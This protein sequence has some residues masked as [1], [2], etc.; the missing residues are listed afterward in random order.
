MISET[1]I[2]SAYYFVIAIEFMLA[3]FILLS[4][5]KALANRA[6]AA[7]LIIFGINTVVSS[8][9]VTAFT[10]KDAGVWLQM[11]VA[12]TYIIGPAIF[13]TA[14]AVLRPT[15]FARRWFRWLIVGFLLLP[16]VS[17]L[18]D[19]SGFSQTVFNSHL[20]YQH[21]DVPYITV[22]TPLNLIP[23]GL[24]RGLFTVIAAG[25][26]V[27]SLL[28]PSLLVAIQ[29]RK[30]KPQNSRTA[31]VLFF[32]ILTGSALE[33]FS[34]LEKVPLPRDLITLTSSVT[35]LL[36]FTYAG[37]KQQE[38]PLNFR[39]IRHV[40]G[41]WP[42]AVKLIFI[43][44]TVIIPTIL[45]ANLVTLTIIR[46]SIA[47][48]VGDNLKSLAT[49]QARN[50]GD[51]ILIEVNNL[52]NQVVQK[53]LINFSIQK[54]NT[55]SYT[56]R[57]EQTIEAEIM[58]RDRLMQFGDEGDLP[59]LTG[60]PSTTKFEID[61]FVKLF[62]NHETVLL[63]DQR[64][65]LFTA[66]YRPYQYDFSKT[67]WWQAAYNGGQGAIYIS[68]PIYNAETQT[69]FVE[70]A[71]PV[72]ELREITGI[73]LSQYSLA[74][75]SRLLGQTNLGETG[76]AELFDANGNWQRIHTNEAPVEDVVDWNLLTEQEEDRGHQMFFAGVDSVIGVSPVDSI[77]ATAD[78]SLKNLGWHVL[79]HQSMNEASGAATLAARASFLVGAGTLIASIALAYIMSGFI[80]RP[81]AGLTDAAAKVTAGELD[82]HADVQ[83]K[84]EFG[85]L[86]TTFNSMTS[87]IKSLVS[88]LE[89]QVAARTVD[90]ERRAIQLQTA[91]EVGR[92]A[93]S[94]RDLDELLTQVTYLISERFDFYHTGIFIIDDTHE[95]AVLRATNS[96]GGQ[97]ML[98]RN[99]RLE[100]GK[101]IV[102]YVISEHEPRIALNVGQDA[103]HFQ[104]PDLPATRSEMALP[105]IT[106]EVLLGV[107]DIQSKRESAFTQDDI[108]T[109]SVLSDQ[110]AIAIE[111]ANLFS[112]TQKALSETQFALETAQR[113]H[114]EMNREAWEDL[115][116]AREN[117]GYIASRD[118]EVIATSA[119]WPQEMRQAEHTA[120][121]IQV[122]NGT[123]AV[124]IQ[125][126]EQMAG[127]IRLKKSDGTTTWTPDELALAEALTEQLS[128]ALDNARLYQDTQISLSRTEA[129]Y[130]V[131]QSTVASESLPVLLKTVVDNIA[132][133]IPA[134]RAALITLDHELKQVTRYVRGG[135]GRE[136][137]DLTLQ[138]D[139][140]MEGLTGW[141]IAEKKPI[142]SSKDGSLPQGA[143]EALKQHRGANRGGIV[144]VPM[145]YRDTVLGT[146]TTINRPNQ[147]DFSESDVELMLAMASQVGAAIENA[148]LIEQIQKRALQLQTASEVGQASSSI[149][150]LEQLLP[151]AVELIRN[152]FSLY[153]VGIFLVDETNTWA[154]LRAG[155]GEA[156]RIQ[157]EAGHKLELGGQSMIGQCIANAEAQIAL[158]VGQQ[159]SFRPNPIL[160]DTRSEMALPLTARGQVIGAL[161]IQS[162]APAAFS[163]EDITALQ[164]M[165]DALANALQNAR[166]FEDIQRRSQEMTLLHEISLELGE[167]E[168]DL[169]VVLE[170]INTRAMEL[171]T[172]DGGGVWMW[173]KADQELELVISH[174][175]AGVDYT[176][177]RITPGEGLTG[178]AFSERKR[179]IIDDYSVWAHKHATFK[180]APFHSAM[181]IPITWQHDVLGVLTLTRSEYHPY[182]EIEQNL[183]EL[184]A[185]Q[186]ASFIQN[187]RLFRGTQELLNREQQQRRIAENAL[188]QTEALFQVGQV[189]I[190]GG[191][192][193]DIL[194]SAVDKIAEMLPADRVLLTTF[195]IPTET[196]IDFV[197]SRSPFGQIDII[198]YDELM[199]GLT[200]WVV[201]EREPALSRKGLPDKRES[202]E[203]QAKRADDEAGSIIVVPLIY[204][205]NL[206]GTLTAANAIEKRDF[207]E[208]DIELLLAMTNQIAPAIENARL[209]TQTQQRAENEQ[210]LNQAASRFSHSLNL[211]T[212]LKTAIREL[213]KLPQVARVSVR[214]GDAEE[215]PTA[216]GNE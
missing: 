116:K 16:P 194:K 169:N 160:P 131:S 71:V 180:D 200:G 113:A 148:E 151:T 125:I 139:E 52:T 65:M 205:T 30:Q 92:A 163:P 5:H 199:D 168:R 89:Q 206:F 166:L 48:Q 96:E 50:I 42:V 118:G 44:T 54:R 82:V 130:Q 105:L 95:F 150:E 110:L 123:L 28:I 190:A 115:L 102:G 98:T 88:G 167:Q 22:N 165:A 68:S 175:E 156:G 114:S 40:I 213:G 61:R 154:L 66:T 173:R 39:R 155:T 81:L 86:A 57:D 29:D 140:L 146:I 17:V 170:T 85:A 136:Q 210:F 142:T 78:V 9:L 161:T 185:S 37:L 127:A 134:D 87:R 202:L 14:V 109:L 53:P 12:T 107:L 56:E 119:A 45:V 117:I 162:T 172:S 70:I 197:E 1:F 13:A 19:L 212:I 174:Q 35:F 145:L 183:G 3:A 46:S 94:I 192:L 195:D 189:A 58:E 108:E 73:A 149:L 2:L 69:Y 103:V 25:F 120:E 80:T 112:L 196:V 157:L 215:S 126:R 129:L 193:Q 90:L 159:A 188:S 15:W 97:R 101:G 164:S 208:Q 177:V 41:D 33:V 122:E 18:L 100:A 184:L 153:Y 203:A 211:D 179:Q 34:V 67:E 121:T 187:A 72:I 176:N 27:F 24:L 181:A 147:R 135:P 6:V 23:R 79:V 111:N 55:E 137:I 11:H 8:N 47:G 83:G 84:D 91:A 4:N 178:R 138:Y 76:R 214:L 43:V 7:L 141:V 186:A 75:L 51:V 21:P 26:P 60:F 198:P 143:P 59:F 106:G 10:V 20:I 74:P 49:A 63:T 77:R 204:R 152:R 133:V 158:D 216:N 207:T 124:P 132:E 201:K 38:G 64:G 191:Q 36:G 62:P 144:V 32:I 182:T 104:N 171:L 99:H 31:W 93:A 209:L 128:L